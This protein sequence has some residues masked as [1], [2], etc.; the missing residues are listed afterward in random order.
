[1]QLLTV[2][3]GIGPPAAR[4][5]DII[6][7]LQ[8]E[9]ASL[10]VDVHILTIIDFLTPPNWPEWMK[11]ESLRTGIHFHVI[12]RY[13]FR[14]SGRLGTPLTRLAYA[15]E[16]FSLFRY[17]H[18]DIVHEYSSVPILFYR[19]GLYKQLLGVHAFHTICVY[20]KK[21]YGSPRFWGGAKYLDRAICSSRHL[22]EELI[23]HGCP[24]NLL[25]YISYG[26]VADIFQG[27]HD[28]QKLR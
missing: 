23:S 14:Q 5:V 20:N 25:S 9:L 27:F 17:L 22:K 26:V 21:F 13:A 11:D 16:V 6:Y 12:D 18:F 8:C 4:G 3:D 19:T 24:P 2:V 10:G 28:R 7:R 15:I 1:M